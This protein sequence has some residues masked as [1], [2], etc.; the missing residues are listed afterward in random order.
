M[1]SRWE[2]T[3][4]PKT[5]NAD[6]AKNRSQVLE[7]I[8]DRLKNPMLSRYGVTDC[9]CIMVRRCFLVERLKPEFRGK[10]PAGDFSVVRTYG[11][12]VFWFKGRDALQH[13]GELIYVGDA[14]KGKGWAERLVE[15]IYEGIRAWESHRNV[16][17]WIR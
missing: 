12:E 8:A 7:L 16:N 9:L 11:R 13:S 10:L 6:S 1:S 4:V 17:E 5:E 15:H 2:F 14:G 3:K